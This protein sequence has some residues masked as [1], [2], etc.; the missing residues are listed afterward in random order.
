MS[1]RKHIIILGAP[2]SG[3][4]NYFNAALQYFSVAAGDKNP[5]GITV[6]AA[7]N[8]MAKVLS[9]TA[10]DLKKGKWA[11]KTM[12]FTNLELDVRFPYFNRL[13]WL[14]D[15]KLSLRFTD[16]SGESFYWLANEGSILSDHEFKIRKR[17]EEGILT[18]DAILL[19]MDGFKI[20]NKEYVQKM[21]EA[22]AHLETLLNQRKRAAIVDFIVTKSDVLDLSWTKDKGVKLARHIRENHFP[23]LFNVLDWD[24]GF[25]SKNYKYDIF[26][27]SCVPDEKVRCVKPRDGTVPNNRWSVDVMKT[28]VEPFY[29][30][31]ENL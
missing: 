17:I 11:A 23:N 2:G 22:M 7:N 8:D 1:N 13:R 12:L 4:T 29:W 15:K 25:F 19:I 14:P 28:E 27:V 6:K 30:L 21:S 5:R 16:F 24:Q 3:K 31:F 20:L 18:C 9:Q 10:P 26:C